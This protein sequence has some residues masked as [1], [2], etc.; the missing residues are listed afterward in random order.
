MFFLKKLK[1]IDSTAFLNTCEVFES[2]ITI[3]F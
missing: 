2:V 3:T 1:N